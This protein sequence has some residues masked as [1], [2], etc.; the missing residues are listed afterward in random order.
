MDLVS[1]FKYLTNPF[2]F[3]PNGRYE[4]LPIGDRGIIG[5]GFTVALVRPDGAIDWMCMP[6]FDSPAMF[7]A[8]LDPERGGL[9]AITPTKPFESVQRYDT[10]TN[11]LDALFTVPDAGVVR[12]TDYMPW[13]DDPRASIHEVHR[14]I[15]CI[16]GRVEL[17]VIFDPRFSFGADPAEIDIREHGVLARGKN[18]ERVAAVLGDTAA[19]TRRELGGVQTRITMRG[20]ERRWMVMSWDAGVPR[21][22]HAYRPFD[23]LRRT[24][25]AWRQWSSRYTYDGPWRQ[26]VHRA[27]LCL[28]LLTY[29]PTGAMVAA[30]T[31]SLPE[32]I[33][34]S[35][36][37]DYR[38]TWV[39]DAAL[40]V[41]ANNLIGFTEEARDFFHFIR[42]T[43]N[44][45][46]GLR[47][48]YGIDGGPVPEEQTLDHLAGYDDSGPV[49]IGN[50]ARDQL[51]LDSAGALVDAMHLYEHFGGIINLRAWRKLSK[52][53]DTV[54]Q[55]WT[56]PDHG[57]WEPRTGKRHNVH[58]KLMSWLAL[59]RGVGIARAF[60]DPALAERWTL[61]AQ[62]I[63]RNIR[64][65]GLDETGRHFVNA[66][67]ES[68]PDAALLLLAAHGFLPESDPR[69]RA[70]TD[71]VRAELGSGPFLYR[72]RADD[73]VGGEEGAFVLAGFW[74][75]EVL[76][77]LGDLDQGLEV[78]N[79]HVGVTNHLGLLAEQVD[80]TTR[81]ALGN[82]PQAFSHLGL[83]N[84]ALRIDRAQRL[85][86]EGSD[87]GPHLIG[88]TFARIR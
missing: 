73:G 49:R 5:D 64:S 17:D 70:T 82:F 25:Y 35:R 6:R 24:R 15:E 56:E 77:L 59:D 83:I 85:R 23:H 66:Y 51:Q 32:W 18:G 3:R 28:K 37:W 12:L 41:R 86:E 38:F 71:W 10:G 33:G 52:V 78:F 39:R 60:G 75:A 4:Q 65:N 7:S 68:R 19:W 53:I 81:T 79:A 31:T 13:T 57:I 2:R 63:H 55:V 43:V 29:A 88:D 30:P 40:A 14:R 48:M 44:P 20:G 87:R 72:Y 58:S 26:R 27:A 76:A 80:P 21:P 9:T 16:D 34:G 84:T 74:L 50:G 67:G 69:M 47:V 36:N 62:R 45:A 54:T 11:I 42:D 22:L 61:G 8:M 1:A 46:A